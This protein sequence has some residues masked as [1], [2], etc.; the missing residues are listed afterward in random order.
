MKRE[1][2]HY[3]PQPMGSQ[4]LHCVLLDM[5]ASMLRGEKLALAKGCLLAL[6]E[7]FYRRREHLAVIG[8]SGTSAQLLQAPGK[9]AAFNADWIQPLRGGGATPVESA[10]AL[11]HQL[12]RRARAASSGRALSLWLL[13]DGRFAALPARPLLADSCHIVDFENEAVALQRCQRLALDW[14]AQWISAAQ[15]SRA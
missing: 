4:A 10:M 7:S 2:L 3:R 6:T 15:L 9:V 8:F 11:A 12:L 1:H 14:E 5:S 13:T